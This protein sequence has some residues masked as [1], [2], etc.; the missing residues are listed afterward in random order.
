MLSKDAVV[1]WTNILLL[2]RRESLLITFTDCKIESHLRLF[3]EPEK[4]QVC[5]CVH[6]SAW[7]IIGNLEAGDLDTSA[8]SANCRCSCRKHK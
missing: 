7:K 5:G 6:Q 4:A 1:G 3:S 8:F 2:V